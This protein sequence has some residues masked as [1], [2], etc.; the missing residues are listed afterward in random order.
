VAQLIAGSTHWRV[1]A[2][3]RN[4]AT[5]SIGEALAKLETEATVE[6]A[7]EAAH[8]LLGKK[9]KAEDHMGEGRVVSQGYNTERTLTVYARLV[10]L[11]DA[12]V[13]ACWPWWLPKALRSELHSWTCS[14]RS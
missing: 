1:T 7:Q 4:P 12:E 14:A 6:A 9:A 13:M 5:Q 2:E 10:D 11:T 8:K 3:R